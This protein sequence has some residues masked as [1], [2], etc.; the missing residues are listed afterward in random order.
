MSVLTLNLARKDLGDDK[1]K[2]LCEMLKSNKKLKRLELEGNL[3]TSRSC[4]FFADA[5]R[6]NNFLRYLDLSNNF[7]TDNGKNTENLGKIF[8]ALEENTMLISLILTNNCL[9]N[10]NTNSIIAMFRKNYS[11]IHLEIFDNNYFVESPP[12]DTSKSKYHCLGPPVNHI[13]EI[14]KNLERNRE[15][16]KIWRLKEWNER[17][18]IKNEDLDVQNN[19]ILLTNRKNELLMKI[20]ERNAVFDFYKNKFEDELKELETN[21]QSNVEKF[22]IETRQRLD[23][24][25]PKKSKPKK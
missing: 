6:K 3:F 9:D 13:V 4:E 1:A 12:T 19:N 11:L 23:K 25:K 2:K 16:D 10:H 21:F 18:F 17:K 24:K 7:L 20:D 8:S 14:K 5:L 22:Y 15:K